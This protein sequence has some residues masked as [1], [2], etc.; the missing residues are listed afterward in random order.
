M[1]TTTR[2][3]YLF[4]IASI[5]AGQAGLAQ[6]APRNNPPNGISVG[7]PKVFDNRTLTLML[8][9][10]S[11][12]LRQMQFIDQKSLA[13]ALGSLQGFQSSESVSNL[14]VS[15]LP[16]Q[17]VKQED[18]TTTGNAG[19]SG[20]PL[21]DTTKKTVTTNRDSVAP[22]P[23]ALDTIPTFSGFTPNYGENA[24]DLLNDQV[25][26]TYQIF[27][28]RMLIERSLSDRVL[29]ADKPRRQGVLGFNVTIDPPQIAGD[30]VAVVEIT[31]DISNP[32]SADG[33]S[34]VSLMPQ[35]KTYNS[36]ALSSK[37]NAFGGSAVV[38]AI[39]IGYSRRDRSQIFYLYRDTDTVSY[40]RMNSENPNQ[41]VFGWMFRPVLGRRSISPGLRQLFA[42]VALPTDEGLPAANAFLNARV[43][44]YW[45]AYDAKSMTS[46][47]EKDA[48][49]TTRFKY[50]LSLN[51]DKP[52]IFSDRYVNQ[53]NYPNIQVKPTSKYQEDLAPRVRSVHWN[54]AGDKSVVI[55]VEG[56]NFFS[57]TQVV[58]G[59]KTYSTATDGLILKS[60]LAFD[61]TTGINAL[62]SRQG[63]VIGRY[64]P[65]VPL[66]PTDLSSVPP[67]GIKITGSVLHPSFAGNRSFEIGLS[68]IDQ[69]DQYKDWGKLTPVVLVNGNIVPFSYNFINRPGGD[70]ILQCNVPDS[71]FSKD[72]GFIKVSYPFLSDRWT[73]T[74]VI[75]DSAAE[76]QI[77]R[78]GGKSFVITS[79]DAL[80]FTIDPED[81]T[82]KKPLT[83]YCWSILA[84]SSKKIKLS[85]DTCRDGDP[86][87]TS[88]SKR[89]IEV[90]TDSELPDRII[91]ISP[92]RA[93]LTLEIPKT[94]SPDTA[95]TPISL[96]QYDAIWVDVAVD[97]VSKVAS[98]EAN[99]INLKYRISPPD[100]TG[101][102]S[103]TIKVEI[104]RDITAKQ[105]DIDLT[106]LDS[107]NNLIKQI[108]VHIASRNISE[109]GEKK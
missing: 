29:T 39:Q 57:G 19:T 106:L 55:S 53:A 18:V 58:V 3:L 7:R 16:T 109:N 31:L 67:G 68:C 95:P 47:E 44:T 56:E 85:S 54:T 6:V 99:Q 63:T 90:T 64:G 72:G 94:A 76:F 36:A 1:R 33:L 82:P 40:E 26:L 91:L 32:S 69:C 80:G 107:N 48:R 41:I 25:N 42:I 2:N 38:K 65:A 51:L 87:T 78:L 102:P 49:R 52:K 23:P 43:K 60:N 8:E 96:H 24:S 70:A 93:V 59:D 101:A 37:S 12:S 17:S 89:A 9:S 108:R 11:E 98:V 79:R 105:G 81:P 34:L 20:T 75:Y 74:S 22:Q 104:T 103:K 14:T 88:L 46:F 21:P 100:K 50:G 61:I 28:L 10:L 73:A 5:L 92:Q 86:N 97:D 62:I 35:E 71:F 84:G 66:A 27:N 30:A 15:T 13:A 83:D 77:T 45:K 4:V